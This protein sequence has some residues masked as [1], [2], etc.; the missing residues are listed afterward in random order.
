[1]NETENIQQ[2]QKLVLWW[3]C[4]SKEEKSTENQNQQWKKKYHDRCS[5]HQEIK[6]LWIALCHWTHK[7]D[8]NGQIPKT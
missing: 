7:L 4:D 1:M 3:T 6:I 5:R 2:S 8:L